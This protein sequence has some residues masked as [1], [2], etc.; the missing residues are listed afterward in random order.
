MWLWLLLIVVVESA[1]YCE[2][3]V[4]Y[5]CYYRCSSCDGTQPNQCVSCYPQYML[6]DGKC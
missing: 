2:G 6:I 1:E 3:D 4:C 5:P